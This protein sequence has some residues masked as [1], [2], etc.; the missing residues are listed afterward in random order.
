MATRKKTAKKKVAKKGTKKPIN[1]LVAA[2]RDK[3]Y[4]AAKKKAS[5]YAK[6]AARAWKEAVKKTKLKKRK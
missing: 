3:K 6:K 1:G 4:K 2:S 5:E